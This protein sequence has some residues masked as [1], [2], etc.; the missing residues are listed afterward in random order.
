MLD[1]KLIYWA[2]YQKQMLSLLSQ[3]NMVSDEWIIYNL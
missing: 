3:E 2:F 1:D